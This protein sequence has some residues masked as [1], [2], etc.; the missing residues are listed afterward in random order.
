MAWYLPVC[1]VYP[2]WTAERAGGFP[3]DFQG[4]WEGDNSA[5]DSS[6]DDSPNFRDNPAG[7]STPRVA[8]GTIYAAADK[9]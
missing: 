3:A 5:D 1:P 9:D 2:A 6:V 4:Y 8:D 7:W